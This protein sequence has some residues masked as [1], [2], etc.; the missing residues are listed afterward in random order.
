MS[1]PSESELPLGV[2]ARVG[3]DGLHLRF[4]HDAYAFTRPAMYAMFLWWA[5]VTVS[6]V[7]SL[8]TRLAWLDVIAGLIIAGIALGGVF[9]AL[10]WYVGA[11][12]NSQL[13][14]QLTLGTHRLVGRSTTGSKL[15]DWNVHD[16]DE[17]WA[18][19]D[20]V[21]PIVAVRRRDG[22]IEAIRIQSRLTTIWLVSE[23]ERWKRTH[24]TEPDEQTEAM[25]QNMARSRA[26]EPQR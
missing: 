3:P 14:L 24:G 16:L 18:S 20:W 13:P 10:G 4:R 22:T 12:L 21:S 17:V 2:S 15:L 23:L 9:P 1:I 5:L 26:S 11:L 8:L 25:L 19:A 7:W 6:G